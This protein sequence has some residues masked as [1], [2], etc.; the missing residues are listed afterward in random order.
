[1]KEPIRKLISVF[2]LSVF[3]IGS[4]PGHLIHGFI[5]H[6]DTLDCHEGS[7]ILG[8]QH[9]HCDALKFSLS[10]F[11]ESTT[12]HLSLSVIST[13]T[14]FLAPES[15]IPDFYTYKPSGRAPPITA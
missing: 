8:P 11:S 9:I 5:H 1:M 15:P 3:L 10:E 12:A 2:I 6:H 4:D 7:V 13:S 14:F